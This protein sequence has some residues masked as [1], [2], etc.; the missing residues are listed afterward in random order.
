MFNGSRLSTRRA[1]LSDATDVRQP[2]PSGRRTRGIRPDRQAGKGAART[3]GANEACRTV[4]GRP[5]EGALAQALVPSRLSSDQLAERDRKARP[6]VRPETP[7][8]GF[9]P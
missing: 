4:Y 6:D 5:L 2:P 1:P 8:R 7:Q 3:G 9:R